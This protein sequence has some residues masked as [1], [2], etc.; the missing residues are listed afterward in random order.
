MMSTFGRF[1]N[2]HKKELKK[3]EKQWIDE[4]E[5]KVVGLYYEK[6]RQSAGVSGNK[7]NIVTMNKVIWRSCFVVV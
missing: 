3:P 7:P 2:A 5:E 4:R 1:L 6:L